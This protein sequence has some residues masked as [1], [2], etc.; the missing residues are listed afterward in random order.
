MNRVTAGEKKI[1]GYTG[2]QPGSEQ[3]DDQVKSTLGKGDTLIPGYSG[4]I[5]GVTSENIHG[6]TYG[7]STGMSMKG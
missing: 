6:H 2:Y 3:S 4:Y 1:P 5:P 7:K